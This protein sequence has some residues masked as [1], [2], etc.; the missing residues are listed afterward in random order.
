MECLREFFVSS[1]QH[2]RSQTSTLGPYPHQQDWQASSVHLTDTFSTSAS[3]VHPKALGGIILCRLAWG[4]WKDATPCLPVWT[5]GSLALCLPANC[6]SMQRHG[7]YSIRGMLCI[8]NKGGLPVGCYSAMMCDESGLNGNS[9]GQRTLPLH[10]TSLDMNAFTGTGPGNKVGS[11]Q[12]CIIFVLGLAEPGLDVLALLALT[13]YRI[14]LCLQPGL[15]L[16]A[17]DRQLRGP[18]CCLACLQRDCRV[19]PDQKARKQ[20]VRNVRMQELSAF[21]TVQQT[22]VQQQALGVKIQAS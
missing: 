2:H 12:E 20:N 18:G 1:L 4:S 7:T 8:C 21:S 19:N 9:G 17:N 13:G 15:G 16:L 6:D 3:R 11:L 5:I 14:L 22:V 10:H